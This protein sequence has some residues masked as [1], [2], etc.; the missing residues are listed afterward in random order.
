VRLSLKPLAD[1]LTTALHAAATDESVFDV[2]AGALANSQ[3]GYSFGKNVRWSGVWERVSMG[4]ILRLQPKTLC[5]A[6]IAHALQAILC[7]RDCKQCV[8]CLQWY[9][10]APR[11]DRTDRRTCSTACCVELLRARRI[12]A[13]ALCTGG[14]I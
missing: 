1:T 13:Q 11:H 3:L 9:S 7:G 5:A 2:A 8:A 6:L 12:R 10:P 4:L 14:P